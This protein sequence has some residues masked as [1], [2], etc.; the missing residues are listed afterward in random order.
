MR[1]LRAGETVELRADQDVLLD[2]H[3]T[4]NAS[5][6]VAFGTVYHFR[7][8]Q[9]VTSSTDPDG[10]RLINGGGLAAQLVGQDSQL[11]IDGIPDA[12][13]DRVFGA[14][15]CGSG[16]TRERPR[17]LRASGRAI[18]TRTTRRAFG[19]QPLLTVTPAVWHPAAS[20]PIAT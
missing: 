6:L 5:P 20:E 13:D 8:R 3:V 9:E 15:V 2:G 17:A 10:T 4:D 11:A 12:H 19:Y 7:T 14:S 1:R 16:H 18:H